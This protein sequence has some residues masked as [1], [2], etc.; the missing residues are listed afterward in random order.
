MDSRPTQVESGAFGDWRAQLQRQRMVYKIMDTLKKNIPFYGYERLQKLKKIA[1]R[2]EHETFNSATC[3]S[4]YSWKICFMMLAM[5]TKLQ[6]C[7]RS[8]LASKVY[9]ACIQ[10]CLCSLLSCFFS[11]IIL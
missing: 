4:E 1:Q 5:E 11:I 7:M 9:Q 2:V 10:T 8:Y 6:N 3:Q